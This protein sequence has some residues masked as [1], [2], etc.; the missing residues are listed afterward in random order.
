[1]SE[2]TT[3]AARG[4]AAPGAVAPR[5]AAPRTRTPT[6]RSHPAV[7]LVAVLLTLLI[8]PTSVTGAGVALPHIGRDTHAPLAA[9]QWV[10][11]GYNLTFASFMLACGSLADLVG[12][13]RVFLAGA[14]LFTAASVVSAS[15]HGIYLLD[16]SRAVAGVGAAA[17]LT[18]G[19]AILA[20]TFEGAARTRVFAAVGIM[21]GAGL[22][23]GAM[24]AGTLADAWGWRS[25]F[26]AHALLMAL[27]MLATLGMR[28][29]RDASASGVDWPGTATFVSGLFLLML[30]VVEGPQR[31]WAS[32]GVLSLLAGSVVLMAL[33]VLVERRQRHPM[34]DLALLRNAR[35][36]ALCLIPV[37]V[38]FAFVILLPLLPN[39][40]LV[41]NRTSS[42][43]AGTTMLLMTLPILPTP[44]LAGKL[45]KWGLSLR[46]VLTAS[47]GLLTLGIAWL[48]LVLHPGV[49]AAELAGPLM[50][51]GVGLG[52][53][54][55]LVDGAVLT[56]VAPE[57]TG[58]AAGFLNT[59]RL[60][61]EAIAIAA[62]GSA[63]V[64]LLQGRL[65]DGS[66][67][68]PGYDGTPEALANSVNSG[69]L[70][71]PSSTVPAALRPQ[72]LD[73]VAQGFTESWHLV[74]WGSAAICA[75]LSAG[76]WLMLAEP[77]RSP[78]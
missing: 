3:H 59:L 19:S 8:L 44:L 65:S 29:S 14:A 38:T 77:R 17:L 75:L 49:G 57:A 13:R 2:T 32:A 60:G 71:G 69:D 70:T 39:Y 23:L 7:T 42:Q 12:R 22:A 50:T 55:G 66:G 11:H 30:G 36:M 64:N 37:V 6:R 20:A 43:A 1:M 46:T 25:F 24:A 18:S 61:S 47:L 58:T 62:A 54:F 67:R 21:T 40:L 48:A 72:F 73:A 16:A 56:V 34:L 51:L 76:I 52:L 53:N 35:F 26:G 5:A 31:G 78:A 10:V 68:V 15:A 9:L 4:A 74:L 45:I 41:A 63:L 28:E 27:V 33:F